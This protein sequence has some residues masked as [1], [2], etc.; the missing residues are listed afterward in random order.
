MDPVVETMDIKV[1]FFI[2]NGQNVSVCNK[3][4]AQGFKHTVETSEISWD[5]D[6]TTNPGIPDN[7]ENLNKMDMFFLVLKIK[8]IKHEKN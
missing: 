8:W 2:Q 5:G 6:N 7:K 1:I 3:P 4:F